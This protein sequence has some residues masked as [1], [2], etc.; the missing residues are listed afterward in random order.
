MHVYVYS[1]TYV[2][3]YVHSS[4]IILT[5]AFISLHKKCMETEM[6][7]RSNLLWIVEECIIHMYKNVLYDMHT[8]TLFVCTY[9]VFMYYSFLM[10]WY[11]IYV[12]RMIYVIINIQA[13]EKEN[14]YL[15]VSSQPD[16]NQSSQVLESWVLR[17]VPTACSS[18][19]VCFCQVK[20]SLLII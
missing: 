9:F 2:C 8:F 12:W 4:T 16:H 14:W 19:N 5:N 11:A 15:R 18:C 10:Q 7:D 20:C 13:D 6:T 3:M 17:S 1:T